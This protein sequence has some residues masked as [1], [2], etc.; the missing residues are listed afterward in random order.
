M[1]VLN[2]F[3]AK[4]QLCNP[5]SYTDKVWGYMGKETETYSGIPCQRWDTLSPHIHGQ[6]AYSFP[7][8]N[9]TVAENYCRN[10]D[11]ESGPWCYTTDS[12]VRWQLCDVPYCGE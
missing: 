8:K 1:C 3:S 6:I 5:R 2:S 9:L 7:E 12:N 10:P 11:G 4:Y